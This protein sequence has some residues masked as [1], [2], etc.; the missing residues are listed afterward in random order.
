MALLDRAVRI[1]ESN[2]HTVTVAPTTGPG[3]AGAIARDHIARGAGLIIAAGG[4]GTI[5]EVRARPTCWP[6]K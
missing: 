2:G 3:A 4:D 6:W 1:L 5:N